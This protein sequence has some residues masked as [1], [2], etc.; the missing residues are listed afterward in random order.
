MCRSMAAG[1][2][3]TRTR[4]S[5]GVASCVWQW[6]PR[7]HRPARSLAVIGMLRGHMPR[8]LLKVSTTTRACTRRAPL[9]LILQAFERA[10]A[11]DFGAIGAGER[12]SLSLTLGLQ[13]FACTLQLRHGRT[14]TI[15]T[16]VTVG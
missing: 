11:L 7:G 6:Q 13:L 12:R 1:S 5:I 4:R 9:G 14:L 16:G 2:C 15:A 3:S 8:E 10:I